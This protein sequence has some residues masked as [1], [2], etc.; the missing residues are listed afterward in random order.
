LFTKIYIS[1]IQLLLAMASIDHQQSFWTFAVSEAYNDELHTLSSSNIYPTRNAAVQGLWRQLFDKH[2][3]IN[4]KTLIDY[5]KELFYCKNHGV[6][7]LDSEEEEDFDLRV[8]NDD[9]YDES[10]D[11]YKVFRK[12]ITPEMNARIKELVEIE[13]ADLERFKAENGKNIKSFDGSS[14]CLISDEQLR[15][16]EISFSKSY[17]SLEKK[18]RNHFCSVQM[19]EEEIKDFVENHSYY[20]AFN[21]SEEQPIYWNIREVKIVQDS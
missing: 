11:E 15:S 17:E 19:T 14:C 8:D 10:N 1:L 4:H 16:H 6:R 2:N 5:W 12:L 13:H 9:A 18:V 21:Y 20:S 7:V 3:L